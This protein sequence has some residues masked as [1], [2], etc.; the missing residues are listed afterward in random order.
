MARSK[1]PPAQHRAESEG[2]HHGA[3]DHSEMGTI[4]IPPKHPRRPFG[5][6]LAG[7]SA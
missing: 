6:D 1:K 7:R 2:D 3:G 4:A 5:A